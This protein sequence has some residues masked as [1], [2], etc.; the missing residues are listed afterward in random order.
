[1]KRSSVAALSAVCVVLVTSAVV[2]AQDTADRDERARTHFDAGRLHYEEGAYDRALV[3]F[4]RAWELSRRP[5]LLVNLATVQERLA[6]YT[7]A[8][9]N[10]RE[11]LRL[12]PD[13]DGRARL[14]RRIANLERLE[15]ERSEGGE[16]APSS[17][18][19]T[20]PATAPASAAA[21]A[22]NGPDEGLLGGAIAA[23]AAAGVGAVLMGAFG[24]L[25]LGAES[26]LASGCGA[27]GACT[28]AEVADANTFALV[29]DIGL[30][31]A[32]AGAAA[33]TVLL[34]VALTSSG[35]SSGE[36]AVLAPWLS[37][38]GAGISTRVRF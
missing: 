3:E 14:E 27:T 8:A 4:Q 21:S 38:E 10:L 11:Y 30:G 12:E 6:M 31:A 29:S 9:E 17:A 18:P 34:I 24:G 37:P 16:D 13:V 28:D 2:S 22:P 26:E 36:S 35:G 23:F 32:L 5:V 33:G 25:A 1:M 7:E 19:A 20:A 15:R